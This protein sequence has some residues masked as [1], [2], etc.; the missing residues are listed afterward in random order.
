MSKQQQHKQ[1]ILVA[2]DSEMNRLILTDMLGDEYEILEAENGLQAVEAIQ[3]HAD[4]LSLILLDIVMP[5]MDGFGV[6]NIMEKNQW[7]ESLPV[8][9]ISSE[10]DAVH[11][12][13]AYEMGATDFISRPFDTLIV[14]R[15]V[16]NTI[17]LYAK[18]KKLIELAV[19][20]IY[21]KEHQN[22]LMI[23]V[24]S[25][26]VE[27]RNGESGQHVRN[28]HV[29]T[30]LLLKRLMEKTDR[31]PLS[32]ADISLIS[33]V[34]ALHDIGKIAIDEA[35]LNKPGKLTDEEFEVMKTHSLIGAQMLEQ[36]TI[37][38]DEPLI[39]V[40]YEI[41]RWHH[42][43]YDGRGYPDGLKGDE[44]PISA[45]VVALADV[46]DAM[47]SERVYKRA[48]PHE[49]AIQ[50]ILEG[51][52]GVFNPLVLECLTDIA[53]GL[54]EAL[55]SSEGD[56]EAIRNIAEEMLHQKDLTDLEHS[57]YWNA[58]Q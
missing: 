54:R 24:L 21:E 46:Y 42:E 49:D 33:T 52:C 3:K 53:D 32:W 41:C 7:L 40:A 50:F 15:R 55:V 31:Y 58:S 51:K 16:V 1:K 43:R 30:E 13:Q 8:I 17:L 10:S 20:Q 25:H 48:M 37:Y 6:L 27:F 23:D 35:I 9:M 44:I 12:K 14:H 39:K 34:S 22:G 36:M 5:E 4:E 56:E 45:Q 19:D 29:L 2:D 18:Q 26:I 11:V 57:S 47:T 38:Q 28:V